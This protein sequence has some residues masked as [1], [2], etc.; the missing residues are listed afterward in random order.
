MVEKNVEHNVVG[1]QC[2]MK[3][4]VMRMA[5]LSIMVKLIMGEGNEK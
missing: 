2:V 4:G 1:I 3:L 5:K